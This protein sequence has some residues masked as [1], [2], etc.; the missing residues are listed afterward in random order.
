MCH[1]PSCLNCSEENW[2]SRRLFLLFVFHQFDKRFRFYSVQ[3]SKRRSKENY[4]YSKSVFSPFFFF[5][6]IQY[7]FGAPTLMLIL[8]SSVRHFRTEWRIHVPEILSY[9]FLLKLTIVCFDKRGRER[10]PSFVLSGDFI[11]VTS[12]LKTPERS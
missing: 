4:V 12:S 5:F 3:L 11:K 7:C 1:Y 10:V 2:I 9:Y 8:G 6:F